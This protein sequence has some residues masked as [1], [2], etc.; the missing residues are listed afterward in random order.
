MK[1]LKKET[2]AVLRATD[3]ESWKGTRGEYLR[4][5]FPYTSKILSQYTICVHIVAFK[6]VIDKN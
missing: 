3:L 2:I 6:F 4:P 1:N 5:H